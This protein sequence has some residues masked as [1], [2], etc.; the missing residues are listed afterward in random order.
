MPITQ[1]IPR[2]DVRHVASLIIDADAGA[3]AGIAGFADV[4]SA[5]A[6]AGRLVDPQLTPSAEDL[7]L[8]DE[9]V[10]RHRDRQQVEAAARLRA[11]VQSCQPPSVG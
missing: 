10:R 11:I 8:V 2:A 9:A 6:A 5:L 1:S 7:D 4:E 3:G